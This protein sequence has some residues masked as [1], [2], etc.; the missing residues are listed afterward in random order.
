MPD[1]I[2]A[3]EL[4]DGLELAISLGVLQSWEV[5]GGGGRGASVSPRWYTLRFVDGETV[6]WTPANADAFVTGVRETARALGK[7][8]A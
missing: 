1:V 7:E 6:D 8:P 2:P 4:A 5:T 3:A